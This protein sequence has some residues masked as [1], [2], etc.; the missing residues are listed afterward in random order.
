MCLVVKG[1]PRARRAKEDIPILKRIRMYHPDS[2]EEKPFF[3][4]FVRDYRIPETGILV[5][6]KVKGPKRFSLFPTTIEGGYIHCYSVTDY[7]RSRNVYTKPTVL[8][9]SHRDTLTVNGY[10]PKGTKYYIGD[11]YDLCAKE[12]ML[13]LPEIID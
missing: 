7:L 10:I 3:Q 12:V 13:T 6:E 1:F 2:P 11:N 5:P 9:K 4:T 8:A